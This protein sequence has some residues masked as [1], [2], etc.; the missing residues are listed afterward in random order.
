MQVSTFFNVKS[1][2]FTIKATDAE[3]AKDAIDF[4]DDIGG[5]RISKTE[6]SDIPSVDYE[7]KINNFIQIEETTCTRLHI[8]DE[9]D[10]QP[11]CGQCF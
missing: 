3:R 2:A 10:T 8:D 9:Y 11:I 5:W 6:N 7:L 4:Y 1:D